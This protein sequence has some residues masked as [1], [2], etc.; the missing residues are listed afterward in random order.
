MCP[1]FNI[2]ASP[3][4]APLCVLSDRLCQGKER[5]VI[6][7]L[8]NYAVGKKLAGWSATDGR[9]CLKRGVNWKPEF[10]NDLEFSQTSSA[11]PRTIRRLQSI[12]GDLLS[13]RTWIT[14]CLLS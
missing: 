2:L 6:C 7:T 12:C 9:A 1:K 13:S 10:S 14:H 8:P 5:T 11:S 3:T 4:P